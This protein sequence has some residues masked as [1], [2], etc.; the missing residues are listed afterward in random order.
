MADTGRGLRR[1]RRPRIRPGHARVAWVQDVL[2]FWQGYDQEF[3]N[4]LTQPDGTWWGVMTRKFYYIGLT[5][6]DLLTRR[7]FLASN[8]NPS[9]FS[10]DSRTPSLLRSPM[11]NSF[12]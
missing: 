1:E 5:I 2:S 3:Y 8:A 10:P 9:S 11:Q 7:G 6:P 4:A 12:P